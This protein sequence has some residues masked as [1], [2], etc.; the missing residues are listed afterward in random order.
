[1]QQHAL[2]APKCGPGILPMA[3]VHQ[4]MP[5]TGI[6]RRHPLR[7]RRL[8]EPECPATAVHRKQPAPRTA[9]LHQTHNTAEVNL[10]RARSRR[11]PF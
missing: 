10:G 1:M 9:P 3:S 5:M 8:H 6:R 2:R 4:H 11:S 7:A